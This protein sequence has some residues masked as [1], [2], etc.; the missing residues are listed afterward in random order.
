MW[1]NKHKYCIDNHHIIPQHPLE[2]K[3]HWTSVDDNLLRIQ[4][5]THDA[6]HILFDTLPPASQIARL[7]TMYRSALS[8]AFLQTMV[9][10]LESEIWNFYKRWV[11]SGELKA[12][13]KRIIDLEHLL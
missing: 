3:V 9:E 12:E 6:I 11:V 1:K 13:N 2:E 10:A 4:R 7:I 8:D 5:N